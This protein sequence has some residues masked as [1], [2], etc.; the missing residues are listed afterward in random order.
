VRPRLILLVVAAV[1]AISVGVWAVFF[2]SS[3]EAQI[4]E[5]IARAATAVSFEEDATNPMMRVGRIRAVFREV[6]I[7]DVHLFADEVHQSVK[8]R[9]E[10]A[11]A[12][13]LL[14]SVFRACTIEGSSLDVQLQAG[15]TSARVKGN[16]VLVGADHSG[17]KKRESRPT[18]I[19]ML[20][21]DGAWKIASITVWPSED[22][23]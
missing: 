12:S 8:S 6:M 17:S 19:L 23:H 7:D 18:T 2:R 13:L 9:D 11:S 1:V 3:D 15:G 10:L 4:K 21:N 20:K 5:A 14:Q 22:P 16:V